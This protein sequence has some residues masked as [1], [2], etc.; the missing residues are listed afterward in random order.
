MTGQVLDLS[1][2]PLSLLFM[3]LTLVVLFY[4]L[5][6][7]DQNGHLDEYFDAMENGDV[8]SAYYQVEDYLDL[9]SGKNMPENKQK[10]GRTVTTLILSQSNFRFFGVLVYFI[11]LGPAGALLYR[12]TCT[13]EFSV[14][15]EDESPYRK[16]LAQLRNILDWL[17]VRITAFMY[18][19][20]GDFNGAMSNLKHHLFQA[21]N[22][23]ESLLQ[24]T[25]LGALG[26]DAEIIDDVKKENNQALALVYRSL[27]ILL[28]IIAMMTVFV[29]L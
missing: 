17:P 10:L 26:L 25:G 15:D 21:H 8:Q 12:L 6:P 22:H 4:C 7:I 23:S 9:K 20:A 11:L 1:L 2:G 13:F 3:L 28:V 27:V 16:K 19:L 14:R 18:A 24:E 29:E 5:D